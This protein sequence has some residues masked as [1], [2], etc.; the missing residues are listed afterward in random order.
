MANE[1]WVNHDMAKGLVDPLQLAGLTYT[2]SAKGDTIGVH[3]LRD[4]IPSVELAGKTVLGYLIRPDQ[5]TVVIPGV[6]SGNNVSVTLP[7]EAYAYSGRCSLVIR[8][9]DTSGAKIPVFAGYFSIGLTATDET[10]DPG[11]PIPSL[12]D[13]LAQIDAM[14]AAT[15]AAQLLIANYEDRMSVAV[16]KSVNLYNLMSRNPGVQLYADGSEHSNANYVTTGYIPVTPGVKYYAG[17]WVDG[18][19]GAWGTSGQVI[20][21]GAFYNSDHELITPTVAADD[22]RTSGA[23]APNGAAYFRLSINCGTVTNAYERV[24]ISATELPSEYVGYWTL[25]PGITDP[26]AALNTEIAEMQGIGSR[27]DVLEDTVGGVIE[28]VVS[29]NLL[30]PDGQ[31]VNGFISPSTGVIT[32]N[33]SYLTSDY[34]AVVGGAY[35]ISSSNAQAYRL[36]RFIAEYDENKQLIPG[37]P[38]ADGTGNGT[39][40]SSAWLLL[41]ESCRYVRVSFQATIK[42][43]TTMWSV[44]ETLAVPSFEP[45]FEPHFAIKDTVTLP[46]TINVVEKL[47][48]SSPLYGKR[49]SWYGDSLMSNTWWSYVSTLFAMVSTNNGVGGTKISG[50]AEASMCQETR[51]N[52]Q[53]DDVVD[54]NTGETTTGGVAI[55]SDVEIIFIGAGTNDWAQNVPLGEKNIQYDSEWNIVESV[56]T[57]YQACHVMFR[58]LRTLRP[59]ARIIVLGTPFGKM[60]NRA[61][62]TNKYGILNNQGLTTLDYGNALCDVAEMWGFVALRYGNGMGINDSNV[63]QLLDPTSDGHLHPTTNDAKEMFRKATINGLLPI[64]YLP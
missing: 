56:T 39:Q 12:E 28:T 22:M 16:V 36:M 47:V 33:D 64:R 30:N 48:S 63:A 45:Y 35:F 5:Q 49:V 29:N 38:Q 1:I 3:I 25:S 27:V 60:A 53:Y 42:K 44:S 32:Q 11:I 58:R 8:V 6:V 62:F 43:A 61:S 40:Y 37:P 23:T 55:P 20:G 52:G 21:V 13:L 14:E 46:D 57:F 54:P 26:V 4:G 24:V 59:N 31:Y 19:P 2:G 9:S 18:D 10:V 7:S 15:N 41:N 17:Y 51:I 50:T 34:I